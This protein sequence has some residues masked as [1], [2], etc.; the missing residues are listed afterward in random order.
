M[1]PNDVDCLISSIQRRWSTPPSDKAKQYIGKFFNATRMGLKITAKVEGNYGTY[2]VSIQATEPNLQAACSCYIGASGYCHHCEAL[3]ATFLNNTSAFREIQP[4]SLNDL[5][6]LAD[7]HEYLLSI[8]LDDLLKELRAKGITQKALAESI[9]MNSRHLSA[10][11]SS[12]LKNRYHYEL[13]ATKLA[14]L[15][16]LERFGKM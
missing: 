7:L 8:T 9:G 5:Q 6:N 15:W 11:K 12:E 10:I 1:S 16:I 3:A 13:G 14:C 4:K 2:T